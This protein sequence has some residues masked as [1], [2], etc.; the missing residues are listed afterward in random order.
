MPGR[1]PG[2]TGLDWEMSVSRGL[3][4]EIGFQVAIDQGSFYS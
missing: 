2:T 4:I 1:G 3:Q